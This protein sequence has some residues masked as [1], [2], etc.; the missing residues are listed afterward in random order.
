[1]QLVTSIFT[2][3]VDVPEVPSITQQPMD[4]AALLGTM[5]TI[6]VNASGVPTPSYQWSKDGVSLAGQISSSLVI[7]QVMPSDRGFYQ[8]TASNT[9][10][11]VTSDAAL[12]TISGKKPHAHTC[13]VTYNAFIHDVFIYHRCEAIHLNSYTIIQ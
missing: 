10:G 1:M 12:L 4:I 11:E 7:S 9:E 3:V 8:C 13:T 2:H 6:A 5:V